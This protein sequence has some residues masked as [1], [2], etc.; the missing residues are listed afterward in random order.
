MVASH[1]AIGSA[2]PGWFSR[3]QLR[4]VNSISLALMKRSLCLL[5]SLIACLCVWVSPAIAQDL[6]PEVAEGLEAQ[7]LELS[8][9]D[10]PAFESNGFML[11][12][13][14]AVFQAEGQA[15]LERF[16]AAN[17]AAGFPIP[18]YDPAREWLA[19]QFPSEVIKLGDLLYTGAGIEQLTMDS[20]GA[21]TGIDIENFQIADVPFLRDL[22]LNDL[23]GNVPFLG[24]YA[25]VDL[26]NL[27]QQ[28]GATD[29]NQTLAQLV[30]SSSIGQLAVAGEALGALQMA[31]LPNLGATK[32][33][34]LPDIGD[35]V[36]ANVPG[37]SVLSFGD[38]PGMAM[39]GGLI[40]LAKQD[41]TFGDKEYSGEDATPK[42]VSGG[43]NG[44]RDWQ[45]IPCKGGCAHIEL[46]D[47]DISPVKGT[48][49]GG[50]WMTRQHRVPDGYGL[51]GSLF[52]EAGAYRLPFGEVFALQVR[53]TDEATGAADWGIAFRVCSN[54]IIDL[55]CTAYF[56][57]VDLP[58]TTYEG[59]TILTGVKDGKGGVTQPVE[60]P[61]G[62]E[63]LRPATPSELQGMLGPVGGGGG[64]CGEGPGGVDYEALAAAYKTIESNINGYDSIGSYANGGKGGNGQTLYG[65]GLGRYQYMTYREEVRAV[66][67]PQEGGAEFLAKA[68]RGEELSIAEMNRLFPP[69][70]QDR[71]FKADQEV[72]INKAMSEGFEGDALIA[73]VGELHTGGKGARVGSHRG[74]AER[75][76]TAYNEKIKG[77]E[78]V[79][80]AT[81][82]YI[83]PTKNGSKPGN[84]RFGIEFHPIYQE[85]RLHAGDDIP[86]AAGAEVVAAD[87]GVVTYARVS[88]SMTKG[89]GQLIIIDHG[90]G[91]ESYYAHLSGYAVKEGDRVGQGQLIGYVG[92]TGGSTG[93]HLHYENRVNGQP[94]NPAIDTDYNA[95]G[96]QAK[97]KP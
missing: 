63:A 65:R 89:Y 93:P 19:G 32:L 80:K 7:V 17:E 69:E 36:V 76:S 78:S 51:L 13:R 16:D 53:G 94:V 28:L 77:G 29:L 84:R 42:P 96:P 57:E 21:L 24:D 2:E 50:N 88:G 59:A 14:D 11:G 45:A 8:F 52:G 12:Y 95:I 25:L 49:A 62:W 15:G 31:D 58:I 71:L 40:P 87:G 44:G 27:A 47:S 56:L 23:V 73:R 60:A 20:I 10:L 82:T 81:G 22:T 86:A 9:D 3:R 74:Y 39:V 18:L 30:N 55:G 54:G 41:I 85:N 66:I 6:L 72:L 67:L 61:E 38:F 43:T 48:W 91:R 68:D 75:L 90:N 97:P 33:G 46:Y 79:C 5:L 92:S 1:A 64:L 4:Y 26:P 35:Q 70:A 83:N 37:L 34:A